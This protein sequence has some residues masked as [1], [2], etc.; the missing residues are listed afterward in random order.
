VAASHQ[1]ARD[2]CR[3]S[4][5]RH[6]RR[7]S[8]LRSIPLLTARPQKL[9]VG[10]GHAVQQ[11]LKCCA[12]VIRWIRAP[13]SHNQA[14][15]RGQLELRSNSSCLQTRSSCTP[16]PRAIRQRRKPKPSTFRHRPARKMQ[17]VIRRLSGIPTALSKHLSK[18]CLHC[19][20][21]RP[22]SY[23]LPQDLKCHVDLSCSA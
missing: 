20:S 13:K 19:K 9:R 16:I 15:R 14:H 18:A 3:T 6:G 2:R 1:E 4:S 11:P 22:V 10:S 17:V 8:R 21:L 12:T 5:G 7:I 23:I